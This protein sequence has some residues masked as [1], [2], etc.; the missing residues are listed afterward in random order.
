MSDAWPIDPEG[1]SVIITNS[2]QAHR[3]LL[4]KLRHPFGRPN[5]FLFE[6]FIMVNMAQIMYIAMLAFAKS[7]LISAETTAVNLC[8]YRCAVLLVIE[9]IKMYLFPDSDN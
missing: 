4:C 1:N 5:R 2:S 8:L 6:V 9:S 3:H 7:A